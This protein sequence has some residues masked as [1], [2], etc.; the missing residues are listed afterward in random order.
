MNLFV[1]STEGMKATPTI[2]GCNIKRTAKIQYHTTLLKYD[3]AVK[4]TTTKLMVAYRTVNVAAETIKLD[5]HTTYQTAI[6]HKNA[7]ST[8]QKRIIFPAG[9]YVVGNQINMFIVI[10]Y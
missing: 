2:T 10:I 6:V 4:N 3:E 9:H 7:K 8:F 1:G 5:N